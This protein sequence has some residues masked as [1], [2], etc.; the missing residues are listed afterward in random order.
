MHTTVSLLQ[1]VTG[2]A[3]A[4]LHTGLQHLQATEFLYETWVVPERT[5]TFKHALI[6]EVAYE[7]LL[8]E[9]RRALHARIVETLESLA[10]DRVGELVDRLAHHA[11][12]GGVWAKALVYCRQAGDKALQR[13]AHRE[14][15]RYFEQ[16]LSTLPH[17]Q[18]QRDTLAPAIDLRL[19]LRNALWTLGELEGLFAHLQAAAALAETLADQ[20]RLGWVSVYLLAHFA[21]ACDPDRALT[22]GQHAL[23]MATALGDEGLTVVAQHYLGGVYRSL[24]D[25]QRAVACFQTNMACLHGALLLE[26][27]G[28]PGL[29]AVFARSHLVVSLA[30]CGAFTAARVPAEEAVRMAEAADHPY[31]RVMAYWAVGV[32][33][34]HQGDLS[35]AVPV[36]TQ[37]LDLAQGAQL[38]LLVPVVAAPLGAAYALAGRSTRALPL[39]EQAVAQAVAMQYLWDQTLRLVWLSEAYLLAGRLDEAGTEAQ[40]ALAFSR[41]HQERGHAAHAL[42]LLGAIAARRNPPE[43]APAATHFQ[44]ARALAE[45]LGMRPLVAHCHLGL[46]TLYAQTGE[47]EQARR[48]LSTAIV[49]YQAMAMTFWLPQA[50]AAL[51]QVEAQ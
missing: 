42:W 45:E 18:E 9:G 8:Q 12:R 24:G 15:V 22:A 31:S 7:S 35:Q 14:A 46:G 20:R 50:M 23:A 48:A 49:M 25:Y 51:A 1:A 19:A 39:L 27:F 21:Q 32:R 43:T 36:L 38:R 40:R 47:W 5:Y 28:L 17:L 6:Q 33:A 2:W 44:Q 3:E 30:E 37:A 29:A 34:L 13:S 26:R 11:L 16:A 10:S 41:A 4:A